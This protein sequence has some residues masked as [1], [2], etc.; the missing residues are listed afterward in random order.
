[1]VQ[2]I[3]LHGS[4]SFCNNFYVIVLVKKNDEKHLIN[5]TIIRLPKQAVKVTSLFRAVTV[6]DLK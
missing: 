2:Q 4:Y 3:W 6:K 1:M 5:L